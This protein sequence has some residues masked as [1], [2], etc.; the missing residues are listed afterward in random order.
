M[1]TDDYMKRAISEVILAHELD[2]I[3]SN[4]EK[5]K[6]SPVIKFGVDPTSPHMHLGH[7]V[8]LRILRRFQDLGYEVNLLMGDFTARVGDPSGVSKLRQLLTKEDVEANVLDYLRQAGRILDLNRARIVYNSRWLSVL[9]LEECISLFA[10]GTINPMI[11]RKGIT[12]RLDKNQPISVLE[13]I[14]PF[15]Q[16]MDSVAMNAEIEI[17]GEDQRFNFV[18]TRELQSKYGKKPEVAILSRTLMGKDGSGKMSKSERNHIPITDSADDM[19]GG[20]MS[21]TDEVIV[22]YFELLTSKS[23]EE[24][25]EIKARLKK[26]NPMGMKEELAY[27]VTEMLYGKEQADNARETF[28]RKYKNRSSTQTIEEI[29]ISGQNQ[30][31]IGALLREVGMVKSNSEGRRFIED[32]IVTINGETIKDRFYQVNLNQ[33]PIVIQVGK[34]RIKRVNYEI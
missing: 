11:K 29:T 7:S 5:E 21:A 20:I 19:Y 33:G 6:R 28:E 23:S 24:I 9:N 27:N 32:G 26:E 14:Y 15:L 13:F 10:K 1:K 4:A 34:K 18:F 30:R 16:G 8:P 25:D 3:L 31:D 2:E 22:P 17:G 12:T